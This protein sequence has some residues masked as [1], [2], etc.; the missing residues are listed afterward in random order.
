VKSD[1][2]PAD[3]LIIGAVVATIGWG[4]CSGSTDAP[5]EEGDCELVYYNTGPECG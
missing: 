2:T 3:F 1:W 4:S 5:Y